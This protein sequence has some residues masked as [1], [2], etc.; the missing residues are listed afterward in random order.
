MVE[1]CCEVFCEELR[2]VRPRP[3]LR[4]SMAAAVINQ[5]F[6]VR[7]QLIHDSVPDAAIERKGMNEYKP[8]FARLRINAIRDDAAVLR[9]GRSNYTVQCLLL[10]GTASPTQ[11]EETEPSR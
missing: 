7:T 2:G 9:L 1:Q 8:R 11:Q 3:P 5:N 4:L 6:Q 10:L